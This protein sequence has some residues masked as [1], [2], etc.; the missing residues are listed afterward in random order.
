MYSK[1]LLNYLLNQVVLIAG[2]T[3]LK[4]WFWVLFASERLLHNNVR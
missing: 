3:I 2:L 1:Q 4:G